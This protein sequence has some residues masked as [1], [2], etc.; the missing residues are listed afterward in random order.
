MDWGRLELAVVDPVWLPTIMESLA[1]AAGLTFYLANWRA[2]NQLRKVR[3]SNMLLAELAT[4]HDIMKPY[5]DENDVE[6]STEI[7]PHNVYDGL[8]SSTNI[9][10]FGKPLQER[11]HAFYGLVITHDRK[12]GPKPKMD[13]FDLSWPIG[14]D[15]K[16]MYL[17]RSLRSVMRDVTLFRN[18][19]QTRKRLRPV[20]KALQLYYED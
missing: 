1:I 17:R 10:Y 8:V 5:H 12:F 11:I 7:L 2:R 3:Y 20:L 16:P 19:N 4:L 18:K 13:T 15:G 9:S 6:N 14:K